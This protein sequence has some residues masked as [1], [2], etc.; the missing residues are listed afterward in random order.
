M[1]KEHLQFQEIFQICSSAESL[2]VAWQTMI[3]ID[4]E[5]SLLHKVQNETENLVVEA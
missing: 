4:P 5:K 2:S 3:F 1:N